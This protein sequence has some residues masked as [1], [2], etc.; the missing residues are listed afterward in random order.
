MRAGDIIV[1]GNGEPIAENDDL[2]YIRDGLGVGDVITLGVWRSGE[3]LEFDVELIEQ[4][5][6]DNIK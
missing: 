5:E 4:Y 1:S 3:Y 6:L 2:L